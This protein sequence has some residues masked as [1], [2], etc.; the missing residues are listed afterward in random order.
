MAKSTSYGVEGNETPPIIAIAFDFDDTLAA[1]STTG[2]LKTLDI[3]VA[4]FWKHTDA[5]HE[6][7]WDPVPA[8]MFKVLEESRRRPE[9]E[10]ITRE[11]LAAW[12]ARLKLYN[13]VT[14]VFDRL[15]RH[16]ASIDPEIEVEF[17]VI[18]SG[19][20]EIL[21]ST[22]IARYFSEI[23]ASDFAYNEKG[24]IVFPRRIVSFTDKTRYLFH[25]AKGL[26][27]P[28][29]AN[30]PFAVNRKT[31]GQQLRV[32]FDQMIFVGD[33]YTDIPCF[34]L[35]RERGG[36]ALGVYNSQEQEK[37]RRAWGFVDV[38]RVSN[39]VSAN[40]GKNADLTINLHMAVEA[41]ADRIALRKKTYQG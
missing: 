20:G 36:Y 9:G 41:I 16:A 35:V 30:Q 11:L 17:Y 25:I 27:G 33:G 38:G 2:F 37:W 21:R 29:Y 4:D 7:G 1:E 22:R 31:P 24:E 23:W 26:I 14:R 34:S 19:L 6:Q 10:R 28:E 40:Y 8:Y 39:L 3:D 15:R 12:G 32:P 5:L 18:S 13:G